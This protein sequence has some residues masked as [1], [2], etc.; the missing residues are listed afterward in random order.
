M[1]LVA[2]AFW[3]LCHVKW[4]QLFISRRL[5]EFLVCHVV[6]KL[7]S[8]KVITCASSEPLHSEDCPSFSELI[9]RLEMS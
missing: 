8:A 5:G 7:L 6:F 9:I 4:V 2:Y 1:L 3:F